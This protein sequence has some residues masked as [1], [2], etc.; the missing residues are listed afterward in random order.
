MDA[1]ALFALKQ[2]TT[3]YDPW[4]T[5]LGTRAAFDD[6]DLDALDLDEDVSGPRA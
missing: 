3:T 2:L 5:D 4:E 6:P 1:E